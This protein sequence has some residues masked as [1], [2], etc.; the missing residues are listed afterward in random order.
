MNCS[1][2]CFSVYQ[3]IQ[4]L[5]YIDFIKSSIALFCC[6]FNLFQLFN[7]VI[8]SSFRQT[9][10]LSK[11]K[12]CA[13]EILYALHIFSSEGI[14]GYIFFLNHEEIVVCAIPDSSESLY[15]LQ[16][17]SILN[18]KILSKTVT[19]SHPFVNYIRICIDK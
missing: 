19:W 15:S 16:L 4:I 5:F 12:N 13:R 11:L 14:E 6:S 9:G 10:S 17:R 18:S 8:W 7:K 2:Y 3:S 1:L